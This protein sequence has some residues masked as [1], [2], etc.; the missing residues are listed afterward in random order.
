V[1]AKGKQFQPLITHPPCSLFHAAIPRWC[2]KCG[3]QDF[4]IPCSMRQINMDLPDMC[5]PGYNYCM[6]DIIQDSRGNIDVF[7]RWFKVVCYQKD[8][9]IQA[10]AFTIGK[11]PKYNLMK[12]ISETCRAH[13]ISFFITITGSITLLVDY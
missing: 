7:K 2:N 9:K 6:T 10:H 1:F 4:G 3:D 11:V 5:S 13:L 8:N 12:V